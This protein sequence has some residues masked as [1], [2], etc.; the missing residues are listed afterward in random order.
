MAADVVD[1]VLYVDGQVEFAEFV[2]FEHVDVLRDSVFDDGAPGVRTWM[3]PSAA[4]FQ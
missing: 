1:V 2:E 4:Q 3:H